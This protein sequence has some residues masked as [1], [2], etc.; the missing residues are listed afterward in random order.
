MEVVLRLLTLVNTRPSPPGRA[1]RAMTAASRILE[2]EDALD[3]YRQEVEGGLRG[4]LSG[5]QDEDLERFFEH[6]ERCFDWGVSPS[7]G[8]KTWVEKGRGGC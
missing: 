7:A 8:A 2:R 4:R 6:V 5:A 3:R 1:A